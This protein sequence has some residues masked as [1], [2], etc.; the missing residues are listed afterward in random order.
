MSRQATRDTRPEVDLRRVLHRRGL[1]FRVSRRPLPE[2]RSTADIVFGPAKVAVYVDGCFWH[3]CPDHG[4]RPASNETWWAEKLRRNRERDA[5]IDRALAEAGWRAV[6]VWEHESAD[7]A[8]DRI[9][10]L[11]RERATGNAGA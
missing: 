7:V 9:E 3:S 4:T 2:L 11:V 5:T 6:R 10:R 8:A 1:R